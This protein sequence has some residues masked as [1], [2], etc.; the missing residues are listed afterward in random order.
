[1]SAQVERNVLFKWSDRCCYLN[2]FIN[3]TGG[4]FFF[5]QR[6][7]QL[8][9]DLIIKSC[10][11][12][13]VIRMTKQCHYFYTKNCTF[14]ICLSNCDRWICEAWMFSAV[15]INQLVKQCRDLL[16]DN[17]G[18]SM[19]YNSNWLIV[20]GQFNNKL[21]AITI[22]IRYPHLDNCAIY[23]RWPENIVTDMN[24]QQRLLLNVPHIYWYLNVKF[25]FISESQVHKHLVMEEDYEMP[26]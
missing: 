21:K 15:E 11:N 19:V 10:Q 26:T 3:H 12:Y 14:C 24:V 25:S 6:I 18:E 2:V 4:F 9:F 23:C 16:S 7:V 22:S 8:S 1:M 5:F 20:N 17:V 13:H